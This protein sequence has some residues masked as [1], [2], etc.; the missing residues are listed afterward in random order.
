MVRQTEKSRLFTSFFVVMMC[1]QFVPLEGYGISLIK[2]ALM[3]LSAFFL[4]LKV[5]YI[6]QALLWGVF[7]WLS[8]YFCASFQ[9]YMRFSTIGYLGL[10][11]ISYIVFYNLIHK[12]V[13]S[14]V[15]FCKLLKGLI[16]AYGV[17]L[18]L[19]QIAILLNVYSFAPI[20]LDNQYYLSLTKLPSLSLEPSHSARLLTVMML[21][22]WRCQELLN[23]GK[24]VEIRDLFA[25]EQ[26]LVTI[27]FLWCMLTMGSGTAFIGLGILCLYF[28]QMRTFIYVIPIIALL[29]YAGRVME[30]E[31]MDRAIRVAEVT[32]SGDIEDIQSEDGSA[33]VR[34]IPIINTLRIDLNEKES[35]LGNGTIS[36]EDAQLAWQ[37]TTDKIA[38]VEQYGLLTF[39][40]SIILVYACM[41]RKFWSMETLIFLF[42]FGMSLGNIAYVWGAM[43]LLTTVRYFQEQNDRGSLMIE[44]LDVDD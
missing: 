24:R 11:V 2:V 42:L 17:V 28:I 7:Y 41:I 8:C 34:I 5:P 16:I 23:D 3:G 44:Y 21:C 26:R 14:L 13:F 25:K 32:V 19:Q 37:R 1:I 12:G 29:F 38:V 22:Y 9:G 15:Y 31:Q 33:A 20:N 30:I 27:A 43:L 4:I 6:S 18:V 39:I 40:I 35:W 10:F 36:H